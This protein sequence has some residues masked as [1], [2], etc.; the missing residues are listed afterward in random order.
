MARNVG[1]RHFSF[2]F[3]FGSLAK[4]M[5]RNRLPDASSIALNPRFRHDTQKEAISCASF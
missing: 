3:I 1:S 4:G 2:D 5:K